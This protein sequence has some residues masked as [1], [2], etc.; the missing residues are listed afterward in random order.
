M[1]CPLLRFPESEQSWTWHVKS[2]RTASVGL[3]ENVKVELDVKLREELRFSTL[4]AETL[5]FK[6]LNQSTSSVRHF[7]WFYCQKIPSM[8][9]R[10]FLL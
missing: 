7:F 10:C 9:N 5:K 8:G 6:L 4:A 2:N 1:V 3:G